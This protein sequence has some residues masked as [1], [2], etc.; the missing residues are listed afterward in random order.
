MSETRRGKKV[1]RKELETEIAW[2]TNISKTV[3]GKKREKLCVYKLQAW[4][5]VFGW[6]GNKYHL[7]DDRK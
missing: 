4:G 2:S 5:F 6:F 1:N 3:K 7:Y